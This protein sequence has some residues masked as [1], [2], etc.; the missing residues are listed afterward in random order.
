MSQHVLDGV[1]LFVG[2]EEMKVLI[3]TQSLG[4]QVDST[5]FQKT[6]VPEE[7]SVPESDDQYV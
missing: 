1:I 5:F 6:H 2:W 4:Y 3:A 7:S